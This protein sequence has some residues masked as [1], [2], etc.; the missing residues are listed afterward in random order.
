MDKTIYIFI[1][2]ILT[3]PGHSTWFYDKYFDETM[4]MII[5]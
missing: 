1:N 5:G 3:F 2:G 4:N